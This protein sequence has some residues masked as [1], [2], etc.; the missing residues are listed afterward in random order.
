MSKPKSARQT[1]IVCALC[2][3]VIETD[4]IQAW[5]GTR[6]AGPG[7]GRNH[8]SVDSRKEVP[9]FQGVSLKLLP[10]RSRQSRESHRHTISKA[11]WRLRW[12]RSTSADRP[13]EAPNKWH[14]NVAVNCVV[15]G[16]VTRA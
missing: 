9:S 11:G 4:T 14:I 13:G 2:D 7:G 5:Q 16:I 3:F 15:V 1:T 6:S 12:G 8:C 10:R